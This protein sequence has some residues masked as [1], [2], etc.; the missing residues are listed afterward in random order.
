MMHINH[1][2]S[3]TVCFYIIYNDMVMVSKLISQYIVNKIRDIFY[4]FLGIFFLQYWGLGCCSGH[5][6]TFGS[7][8]NGKIGKIPPS[9]K[10]KSVTL[11][12]KHVS[13][14][15]SWALDARGPKP[16]RWEPD[17][18]CLFLQILQECHDL[19]SLG[20]IFTDTLTVI[21]SSDGMF[22]SLGQM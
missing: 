21:L 8:A 14:L 22:N 19:I 18:R 17:K 7:P 20:F 16:R 9:G 10:Y 2:F 4:F 3:L 11:S 1:V 13:F 15:M 6:L 12:R 5:H